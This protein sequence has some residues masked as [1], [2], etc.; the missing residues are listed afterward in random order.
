MS[1]IENR[2]GYRVVESNLVYPLDNEYRMLCKLDAEFVKH[3]LLREFSA[4]RINNKY[5]VLMSNGQI[6]YQHDS[7]T[8]LIEKK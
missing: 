8:W 5:A 7:C 3:E 2:L 6:W 4:E 1:T